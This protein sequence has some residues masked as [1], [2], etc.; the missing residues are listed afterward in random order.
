MPVFMPRSLILSIHLQPQAWSFLAAAPIAMLNYPSDP[1]PLRTWSMLSHAIENEM[2]V[3]NVSTKCL[4]SFPWHLFRDGNLRPMEHATP[5]ESG[6]VDAGLRRASLS[7]HSKRLSRSRQCL[8][9]H[10]L[11]DDENERR[12]ALTEC[13]SCL[14]SY[15]LVAHYRVS[16]PPAR[17]PGT[18]VCRGIAVAAYL[19]P[20]CWKEVIEKAGGHSVTG[21]MSVFIVWRL[22]VQPGNNVFNAWACAGPSIAVEE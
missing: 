19:G 10:C 7:P 11:R 8:T 9:K 17:G 3:Q 2:F 1:A 21:G 22:E 13:H 18:F 12:P 5:R 20:S 6:V 14:A 16:V 15:L 4:A